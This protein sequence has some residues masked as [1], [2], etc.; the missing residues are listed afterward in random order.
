MC[1]LDYVRFLVGGMWGAST[2]ES[3]AAK[4]DMLNQGMHKRDL[5]HHLHMLRTALALMAE[6]KRSGVIAQPTRVL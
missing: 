1:F 3:F 4:A 2:P 6:E 5:G